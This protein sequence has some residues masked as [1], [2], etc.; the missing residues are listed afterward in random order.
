MTIEASDVPSPTFSQHKWVHNELDTTGRFERWLESHT[1][2]AC[3][4]ELAPKEVAELAETTICDIEHIVDN[5]TGVRTE[6]MLDIAVRIRTEMPQATTM[7]NLSAVSHWVPEVISQ[8]PTIWIDELKVKT[9]GAVTEEY[10][11]EE[12]E[13][14]TPDGV[15]INTI[16]STSDAYMRIKP[17]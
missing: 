8:S 13:P 1:G 14:F 5:S 2:R 10:S 9:L 12:I 7:C 15:E 11:T 17:E 3:R 4:R 16:H 6:D